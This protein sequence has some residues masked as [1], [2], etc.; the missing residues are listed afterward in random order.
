MGKR[1]LIDYI[2]ELNASA[3]PEFLAEFSEEELTEYLDK[4]LELD[5]ELIPSHC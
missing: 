4:L 3:K 5:L 1:E 2:C